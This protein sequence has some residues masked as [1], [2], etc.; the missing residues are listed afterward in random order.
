MYE[1]GRY[2][3]I[4]MLLEVFGQNFKFYFMFGDISRVRGTS[5]QVMRQ[6]GYKVHH[7]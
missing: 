2:I 5:I 7:G 6:I 3:Y 1:R 4:L